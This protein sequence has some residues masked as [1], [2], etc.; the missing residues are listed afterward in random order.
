MSENKIFNEPFCVLILTHGRANNV[1]THRTLRKL[2]YTGPIYLVIDNTDK[3][4]DE[5]ISTYGKN[6]V[7][8]DKEKAIDGTDTGDN[9]RR[10]NAVV[11][12]RNECNRIAQSLGFK[13][14]LV[15][16]DDYSSFEF[17][18]DGENYCYKQL[19]YLDDAFSAVFRFLKN[20]KTTCIA[21]AH[22]GG[23]YWRIRISICK[24]N[25]THKEIDE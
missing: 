3:Q 4:K 13:Y 24:K 19:K 9:F 1:I 23:F 20:T 15:L 25:K 22:G 12:A 14:Y 18:F 21:L 17:R 5:Y 11:Y 10:K 7:I 8:F 6:V 2:G 16:D